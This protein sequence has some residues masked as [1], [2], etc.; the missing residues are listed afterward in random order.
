MATVIHLSYFKYTLPQYLT[1]SRGTDTLWSR[2]FII[3]QKTWL[4]KKIKELVKLED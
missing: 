4:K 2:R 1:G 3:F